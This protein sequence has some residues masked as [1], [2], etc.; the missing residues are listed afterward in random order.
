MEADGVRHLSYMHINI[1]SGEEL[2]IRVDHPRAAFKGSTERCDVRCAESSVRGTHPKWEVHMCGEET[3]VHLQFDSMLPGWA[4]GDGEVV[5]GS[6][7]HPEVFGWCVPQSRAKVTGALKYGGHENQVEGEGYQDHNWGD[8]K[9]TKYI[10]RWHW[11]RITRPEL[12]TVFADVVTGRSCGCVHLPLLLVA[13]GDRLAFDTYE[14]EWTYEDFQLDSTG[15]QAYP[16][17]LGF[18][19]AERDATGR[20]ELVPKQVLEL[21]DMLIDAKVPSWAEGIIGELYAQPVYYSLDSGYEGEIDFGGDQMKVSGDTIIEYMVFALRKGQEPDEAEYRHFLKPPK[22][23]T[24][25]R[26]E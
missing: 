17:K 3:E 15:L 23:E 13:R 7:G 19:F 26:A 20:F 21:D 6:Y 18:T 2:D 14:M 10:G 9:L 1:P 25:H 22:L 4:R 5:I 12:T 11:G 8:F 24:L 16:R